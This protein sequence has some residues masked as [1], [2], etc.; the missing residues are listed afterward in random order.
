MSVDMSRASADNRAAEPVGQGRPTGPRPAETGT[1]AGPGAEVEAGPGAGVGPSAGIGSRSVAALHS[2]GVAA[3]SLLLLVGIGA[4]LH[5]PVLIPPIA[6]SAA[7]VCGVPALPLA[8]PRSVV[9]GHLL[10]AGV[11]YVALAGAG[12]APWVAALAAGVAVGIMTL[13]RT[14]HSPAA[15]TT[16]VVVLQ[17]PDP[18]VFVPLLAGAALLLVLAGT[19]AS[20]ARPGAVRYPVYWWRDPAGR[21]GVRARSSERRRVRA[22]PVTAAPVPER[23]ATRAPKS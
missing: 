15:A 4:L 7:I 10:C 16:V 6:A 22:R 19:A 21:V 23:P 3:A 13:A 17:S 18:K 20:R 11:G 9:G 2:G 8:Q 12:G 1:G 14:P 5:E